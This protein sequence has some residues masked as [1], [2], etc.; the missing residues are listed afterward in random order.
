MVPFMKQTANKSSFEG[1]RIAKVL[2][3]AGICSRREAERLIEEGRVKVDGKV[4]TSPA[5]NV[6]EANKITVDNKLVL[7]AEETRVWRYH[8]PA[9]TITTAKD[10]QGRPTVFEKM[11]PEMPRV[12]S[13]GRLDFN[14]EGLLLLTNDG[15]LARHMELP[16]NAWLRH[17]RVRVYGEVKPAK[18]AALEKGVTISGIEYD[19]IKVEVEKSKK[20]DDTRSSNT[21][22]LVTIR[23]GKNREVRK[24]MEH[25]D[26]QVTRLI[27]TAF[28]P[29][30]LGKL[31][32]G[33]IEEIP[34]RALRGALG[35]FFDRDKKK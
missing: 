35:K 24:I 23:E 22:L 18:L 19:S 10:P 21:W 20:E 29:F 30:P 25:M 13:I 9:G 14:T 15:E 1:E 12:V 2:G 27:R 32:R 26:L 16:A 8:K 5:L 17:Y 11:P 31:H 6:T 3:R 4:I 7:A 34:P 33:A 28:G